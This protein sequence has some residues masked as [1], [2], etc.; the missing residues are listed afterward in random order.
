MNKTFLFFAFIIFS[1]FDLHARPDIIFEE[2]NLKE[3]LLPIIRENINFP[4]EYVTVIDSQSGKAVVSIVSTPNKLIDGNPNPQGLLDMFKITLSKGRAAISK[5]IET[6]ITSNTEIISTKTTKSSEYD[7]IAS[8]RI[9]QKTKTVNEILNESSSM[10]M[11][12]TKPVAYWYSEDKN[13]FKRAVV[14]I[15]NNQ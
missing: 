2:N 6:S 7:N 8:D 11:V 15:L 10:V 13:Y 3:D 12:N 5:Y 9:V 14:L 1:K 4:L